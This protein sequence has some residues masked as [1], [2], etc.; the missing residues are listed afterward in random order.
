[1][2]LRSTIV[3][4]LCAGIAVAIILGFTHFSYPWFVLAGYWAI[5]L[6]LILFERGRYKPKLSGTNFHPTA[7]RYTD[8]VTGETI[9]VFV[10]GATGERD[11]RPEPIRREP[12]TIR[13]GAER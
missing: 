8:P 5:G 12:V 2:S 1:M 10:D 11:Y 3:A 7:E 13:S 9:V 4:V 6:A